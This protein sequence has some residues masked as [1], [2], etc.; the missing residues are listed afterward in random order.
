[1]DIFLKD[2]EIQD[3]ITTEKQM[4]VEPDVLFKSMK[5]KRGHKSAE[6]E[7]PQPDGSSFVIKIRIS[8]ENPLDFSVILGFT[9][10]KATKPFL[11]RRY[12]GKSHE[13]KN[14]LENED[15]FY[16]FHIHTATERYQREG[17]KE[18]YFAE[19][20]G[21]YSTPREALDCLITDCNIKLPLESQLNLGL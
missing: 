16:D 17:S 3:L 10:V 6:H 5:E 12:N 18:E 11:L 2:T 21:S 15:D 8:I 4:T 9:P 1:M 7:M 20:S 19:I 14:R 13:H